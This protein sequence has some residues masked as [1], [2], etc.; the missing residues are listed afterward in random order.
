MKAAQLGEFLN[1]FGAAKGRWRPA[2]PVLSGT[3]LEAT[4]AVKLPILLWRAAGGQSRF[5]ARR[6]NT[7]AARIAKWFQHSD[8]NTLVRQ[9]I[10]YTDFSTGTAWFERSYP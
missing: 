6:D 5:A 4:I 1:T 7:I 2:P 9:H 8:G 10:R 3:G